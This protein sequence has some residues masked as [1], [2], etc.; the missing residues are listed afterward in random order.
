MSA[1]FN[2]GALGWNRTNISRLRSPALY[3]LSY[4]GKN[5]TAKL[6]RFLFLF[7]PFISIPLLPMECLVH[8]FELLVGDMRINLR[9]RDR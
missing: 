4:K 3:P 9:G 5:L 8:I 1:A 2:D 6:S 7:N